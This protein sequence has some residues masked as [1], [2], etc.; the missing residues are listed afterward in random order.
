MW[1]LKTPEI[2]TLIYQSRKIDLS[3][4]K[5]QQ[6]GFENKK[7]QKWKQTHSQADN[8]GYTHTNPGTDSV[9]NESVYSVYNHTKC[10]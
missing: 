10:I 9:Y 7:K 2:R 3:L 8:I 6:K 4:S 1:P 5:Y